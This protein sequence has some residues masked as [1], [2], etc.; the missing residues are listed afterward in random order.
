LA[1]IAP[2]RALVYNTDQGISLDAVV[3]PPYDVIGAEES[4]RL[5]SNCPTNVVRLIL[6]GGDEPYE[7]AAALLREWTG[8]GVLRRMDEPAMFVYEQIYRYGERRYCRSGILARLRIEDPATGSI[9]GH[10]STLAAPREDR[11]KLLRATRTNLSPIF[12]LVPDKKGFLKHLIRRYSEGRPMLRASYAGVQNIIY[13]VTNPGEIGSLREALDPEPA[14]I[15]DGHHRYETARLFHLE[16]ASSPEAEAPTAYVL[17]ML[18]PMTDPGLLILATHRLV[19]TSNLKPEELL[20]RLKDKFEL[21]PISDDTPEFAL[22][23]EKL[24]SLRPKTAFGIYT[25]EGPY[26]AVLTNEEHMQRR[27]RGKSAD[28][29]GLDV[30]V[31][32]VLV[33]Q[34]ALGIPFEAVSENEGIEYTRDA[35]RVRSAV[36][37]GEAAFGFILRPTPI[38]AMKTV[39]SH[40]ELMP[41]KA[42][43]FY[44]K[45]LS[46][47]VFN[48]LD[49]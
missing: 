12:C 30:S 3:A 25:K 23:C 18:V 21:E 29:H 19:K 1:K 49:E 11:L 20:S 10:E 31:L 39:G 15:A 32:H 6:P 2:F 41:P 36:D 4:E 14:F 35:A 37:R 45:L 34:D 16:Q 43:Y 7:S 27:V 17:A 13:P 5:A 42:T 8:S 28:W 22:L 33:L 40:R 48:V 24:D 47:L 38:E 26:V 9:Y 44:P 46:G